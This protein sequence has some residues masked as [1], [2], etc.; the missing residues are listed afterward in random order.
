V[1]LEPEFQARVH[2]IANVIFNGTCTYLAVHVRWSD[3]EIEAKENLQL[4]Y[5]YMVEKC[6]AAVT[7]FG[8]NA[9]FLMSCTHAVKLALKQHL[10]DSYTV[11]MYDATLPTLSTVA[12]HMD[13]TIDGVTSL[14]DV[15]TEM[16]LAS[17]FCKGLICTKSNMSTCMA[18]LA[19]PTFNYIDFWDHEVSPEAHPLA[20]PDPFASPSTTSD[21]V[22]ICWI[23]RWVLAIYCPQACVA[24]SQGPDLF[25]RRVMEAN[26]TFDEVLDGV[27]EKALE[28]SLG[29]SHP[30][31]YTVASYQGQQAVGLASNKKLRVQCAKL[32]LG[33][34]WSVIHG[35]DSDALGLEMRDIVDEASRLRPPDSIL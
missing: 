18:C 3:K 17:R 29:D 8:C 1:Q 27:L 13:P 14:H 10:E 23:S 34:F 19:P 7:K 22:I 35:M 6:I 24:S 21:G 12:P 11:A 30:G 4:T 9:F 26:T 15:A 16:I 25:K 2:N 31:H 33:V 28:D 20:E 32:A 5:P